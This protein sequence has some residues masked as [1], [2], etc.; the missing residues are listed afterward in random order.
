MLIS[1]GFG[2]RI[3]GELSFSKVKGAPKTNSTKAE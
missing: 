1:S 3:K 2:V